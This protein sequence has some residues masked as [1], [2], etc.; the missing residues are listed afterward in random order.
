[1]VVVFVASLCLL[2]WWEPFVCLVLGLLASFLMTLGLFVHSI[3]GSPVS[4]ECV[5]ACGLLFFDPLSSKCDAGKVG[6]WTILPTLTSSLFPSLTGSYLLIWRN[7][8]IQWMP[9]TRKLDNSE[10]KDNS[11]FPSLATPSSLSHSYITSHP[12]N[13]KLITMIKPKKSI[14]EQS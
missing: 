3:S 1:M 2:L 5:M 6:S 8:H 9:Q 7:S 14:P 10:I 11:S 13:K 4:R 12:W